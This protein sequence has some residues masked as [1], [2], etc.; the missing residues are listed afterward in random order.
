MARSAVSQRGAWGVTVV[1]TLLTAVGLFWPL[2]AYAIPEDDTATAPEVVTITNYRADFTL[3]EDGRL[4]VVENIT[5]EFPA[6]RHGIFRYWDIAD[7]SD[8]DARL[9]PEDIEVQRD[10]EPEPMELLWE[11]G[12][13]YRVAKIGSADEY[14]TSGPHTYTISYAVEG[15][16]GSVLAGGDSGSW[17]E[18]NEDTR[19]A[20]YWNLIPGGWDMPIERSRLTVNLPDVSDEITCW[21]GWSSASPAY[22]CKVSADGERLT[23]RTGSLPPRTPVTL[24]A[25]LDLPQ[26]ERVTSPWPV[27]SDPVFSRWPWLAG[28]LGFLGVL[29]L[30]VGKIWHRTSIEQEPGYP[31]MYAP[32]EGLGPVQT[33]YVAAERAPAKALIATLLYAAERGLV[34]LTQ[35]SASDWTIQ[36]IAQPEAW[37]QVDAVTRGVGEALKVD[38]PGGVFRADGGVEAGNALQAAGTALNAETSIWARQSGLVVGD[39]S[40][41]VGRGLVVLAAIVAGIC[42]FWNPFDITMVGLPFAAFAIGGAGLLT[43]G[44]GT[45][46][47]PAGREVWSKAEGFYRLL[48]TPSAQDRFDF[49]A[50]RELYTAFIPYAVAFD[51]AEEWAKKYEVSTG[52]PAPVPA[53]YGGSMAAGAYIGGGAS[54]ASFESS[55]KSSIGAYEA[56]QRSSSSGGGGGGGSGGGGGGGGG[57]GSW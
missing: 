55:V 19:S 49:S 37:Q 53:Y 23:V 45:R 8:P 11:K 48:S 12:R 16:L 26:P 50:N 38:R 54:F 42:F 21:A 5:A 10:G 47:T 39:Q 3:D 1:A 34:R 33:Y 13:R 51:C 57:G 56:S 25:A 27:Q 43:S 44:V 31:V 17:S 4:E 36:G 15:A 40:E 52:Q 18:G 9:L 6:D 20:F 46:R 41:K 2:V 32:P 22:P 7:P 14:L 30:V 29:G 24:R 28:V 35:V